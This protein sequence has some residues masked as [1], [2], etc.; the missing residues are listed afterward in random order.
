M[1]TRDWFARRVAPRASGAFFVIAAITLGWCA[2]TCLD[3]GITSAL[4]SHR[5]DEI[6]QHVIP[7]GGAQGARISLASA[8]RQEADS[9]GLVGRIEIASV[10][11]S[12]I[13][14]EGTDSVTLRRAVG[15]V[16]GT[17]FP[18]EKGNVALAAHRETHFRGL[19]RVR[20]GDTIHL[21]TPDGHFTYVVE[22]IDVVGPD[23][24]DV[25][26]PAAEPTLT[27]ITCFP[28]NYV[29]P[30]PR[31]FVVRARLV[32]RPEGEPAQ[33]AERTARS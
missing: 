19:K 4:Q 6:L 21:T 31:R 23:R 8:T 14:M 11:L 33:T 28:F 1:S 3:A 20:E 9:S 32:D 12:S 29:G 24:I 26:R 17:A 16:Q 13:I 18:G 25:L 7:G 10:K 5:L 22:S 27:L 15:H 30:A 2:A